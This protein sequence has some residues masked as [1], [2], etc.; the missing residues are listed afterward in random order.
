MKITLISGGSPPG[1]CGVADYTVQLAKALRAINIEAEVF[2]AERWRMR[3]IGE[4][5]QL[6]QKQ[7]ADI[8]HLQYPSRG[9]GHRLG[10]QLLA[11]RKKSVVTLHE[12]S[13]AHILRKLSLYP[14]TIRHEH[15]IFT[16]EYE[17]QF[18]KQWAPWIGP[19]S[20]IIPIGSNIS[21]ASVDVPRNCNEIAYFGLIMPGKGLEQVLELA[22]ILKERQPG[23]SVRV[24]GKPTPEHKSY[25]ER[26]RNKAAQLPLIWDTDLNNKQIAERLTQVAIAYLPFPDGASERRGSL[27]AIWSC[28]VA[29]VTTKG[30]QTP[31][32]YEGLAQWAHD[33]VQAFELIQ[34][35][36]QDRSAR[37]I[38]RKRTADYM[39]RFR[40]SLIAKLHG[41]VYERVL[42]SRGATYSLSETG[43][44]EST[45]YAERSQ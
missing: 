6:L 27:K 29:A 31:K 42:Q 17:R 44:L 7:N 19:S 43:Q 21:P 38:L 4:I 1:E 24:I 34:Y 16:S 3:D 22:R 12:A 25:L 8:L 32:E 40:W 41:N 30:R 5:S 45:R 18:A 15:L 26:L 33:P 28:G 35:L 36:R 20:S 37:D 14:F 10:P 23:I 13:A 9:F 2:S 39:R 11:L